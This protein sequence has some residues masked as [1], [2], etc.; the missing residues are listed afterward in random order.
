MIHQES[1][2][3]HRIDLNWNGYPGQVASY[4]V[5]AGDALAVVETGPASTL[6]ALLDGIRAI[7]RDP[8]E[9]THVLVTHIHLDHSGGAGA[10]LRHTPRAKVHVHPIG[11]VHLADPS[12]LVASARQLYGEMMDTLWGQ[13]VPVPRDRLTTVLNGQ[14]VRIGSRRLR[15]IETPG[16]AIHHHA[17]HDPDAGA[18][19]TGDVA[20]IRLDG[21][22]YVCAPTPPP[23]IDFDAWRRSIARLRALDPSLLLLTHFGGVADPAWHLDDLE[24]RLRGWEEWIGGHASAGTPA[25]ELAADAAARAGAEIL[26]ATGSDDAVDAYAL[27]VPYPMMAAGL[28]RWWAKYRAPGASGRP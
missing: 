6:G 3:I 9:V 10:L 8:A 26:A 17:W 11:S 27:T 1:E 20:G 24:A 15:A 16:H 25:D 21:L 23:D 14:E 4:L 2:G 18:V 22:P 28:D 7:G 13:I 5:D 12:R 19:F